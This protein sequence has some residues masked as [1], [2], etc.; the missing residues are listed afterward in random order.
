[1]ALC[2]LFLHLYSYQALGSLDVYILLHPE[3]TK[4]QQEDAGRSK[5]AN[6]EQVTT[7]YGAG[8]GGVAFTF[9]TA[10]AGAVIEFGANTSTGA[11]T[12]ESGG[13]VFTFTPAAGGGFKFTSTSTPPTQTH[14]HPQAPTT[15]RPI[16]ERN[17]RARTPVHPYSRASAPHITRAADSAL[18]TL[19]VAALQMGCCV[20]EEQ[21]L[22]K[23]A[24]ADNNLLQKGGGS[25]WQVRLAV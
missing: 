5:T 19:S 7:V 21:Q 8:G 14:T 9:T 18:Q 4:N 12:G 11:R 24:A 13:H 20:Q 10:P 25:L 6:V 2:S 17:P 16:H 3:L 15:R 1:M 22:Y 23:C